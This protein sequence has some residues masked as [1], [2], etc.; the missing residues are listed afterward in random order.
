MRECKRCKKPS[1]PSKFKLRKT[2]CDECL[3]QWEHESST[4]TA[5]ESLRERFDAKVQ[6]TSECWLWTGA[7]TDQ[8]YGTIGLLGRT[9]YAHR[10]AHERYKG[11]IPA[12]WDVDHLCHERACVNP[13]HLEAVP[14]GE[15][16]R[17]GDLVAR[18]THCAQG[19][20]WTE[21]HI[22]V[23]PGN[24]HRMCGTCSSERSRLWHQTRRP[25][26]APLAPSSVEDPK[27]S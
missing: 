10:L 8:D 15:N 13:D 2:W 3:D 9:C 20:P 21:E 17:R 11:P 5:Q 18:K 1:P 27:E 14:H 26:Q 4:P 23:R 19:H 7:K 24:G 25:G 12:G 22:Y 6:R 16:V